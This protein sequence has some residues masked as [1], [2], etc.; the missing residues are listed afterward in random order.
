[1]KSYGTCTWTDKTG[2]EQ[3]KF[4]PMYIYFVDKCLKNVD[5][6]TFYGPHQDF[7]YSKIKV[8][9]KSLADLSDAEKG[10]LKNLGVQL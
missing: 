6:E 8:D 9:K 5:G 1:M 10:F 7:D 4:G 3:S 2:R